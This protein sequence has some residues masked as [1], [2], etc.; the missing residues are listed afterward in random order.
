MVNQR[1]NIRDK[2]R[3]VKK[4][5][6]VLI[7]IFVVILVGLVAYFAYLG[8]SFNSENKVILENPVSALILK[9]APV[10][11][12]GIV[13]ITQ[14]QQDDIIQEAILEFDADYINYILLALGV[15]DLH[16]SPIFENPKIE[17]DVEEVWSSEIVKG[18]PQTQRGEIGGEDVRFIMTKEEA[19]KALLSNDIGV[20]MKDSVSSGRTQI[21][22]VVGKIE[23]FSKGYLDLYTSLTGEEAPI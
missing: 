8:I 9:Y 1:V 7:G 4:T 21:E 16:K 18:S 12:E 5:L 22:M 2:K 6:K 10:T 11:S 13:E 17:L 14:E 3:G 20:F 15:G 23:L 19:V